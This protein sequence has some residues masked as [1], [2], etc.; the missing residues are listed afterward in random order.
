VNFRY[1]V[2]QFAFQSTL[3]CLPQLRMNVLRPG[4]RSQLLQRSPEL[5]GI[6]LGDA[7]LPLGS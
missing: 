4:R 2:L 6:S 1:E 3:L 5:F 7:M